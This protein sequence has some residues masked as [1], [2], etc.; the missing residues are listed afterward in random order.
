ME[1]IEELQRKLRPELF[2]HCDVCDVDVRDRLHE[3]DP[4]KLAAWY[5]KHYPPPVPVET[6]IAY[7]L[8]KYVGYKIEDCREQL[9]SELLHLL[10]ELSAGPTG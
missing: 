3:H 1:R 4:E 7:V 9:E 8:N 6:Q 5:A 10:S 2:V